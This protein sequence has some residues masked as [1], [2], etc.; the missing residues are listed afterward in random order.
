MFEPGGQTSIGAFPFF[1][2]PLS[3]G[4]FTYW[5]SALIGVA[6]ILNMV[7]A[8]VAEPVSTFGGERNM[9]VSLKTIG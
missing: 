1:S 5:A 7:E 3:P 9:K 2:L 4:V 6:H 8:V